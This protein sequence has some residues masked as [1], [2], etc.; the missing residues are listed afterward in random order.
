MLQKFGPSTTPR[1]RAS[2]NRAWRYLI[3]RRF[4]GRAT[5]TPGRLSA[6]ERAVPWLTA[7]ASILPRSD[8]DL[9]L[10]ARATQAPML[11]FPIT[12]SSILDLLISASPSGLT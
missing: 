3:T 7:P 6:M 9:A 1:P 5:A 10:I 12:H 8:K 11:K 2:A 4:G